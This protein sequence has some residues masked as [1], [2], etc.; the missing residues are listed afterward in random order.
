MY[1]GVH[2][3]MKGMCIHEHHRYAPLHVVQVH[4]SVAR[5]ELILHGHEE[6]GGNF[7]LDR[8][9]YAAPQKR[10]PK[11]CVCMYAYMYVCVRTFLTISF[12]CT[13]MVSG[14]SLS[15][16]RYLSMATLAHA[17]PRAWILNICMYA[18]A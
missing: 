7:S 10:I 1:E 2:K 14:T 8:L 13:R 5:S 6:S 17:E 12:V 16:W 3:Y 4:H 11:T 15:E 9:A 18:F